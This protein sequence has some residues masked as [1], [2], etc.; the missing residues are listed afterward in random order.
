MNDGD[1]RRGGY[2]GAVFSVIVISLMAYLTFAAVQG[3]YGLFRLLQVEAKEAQLR[4]E[5]ERL[6]AR[7]AEIANR[8]LRLSVEHLDLDLLDERARSVLGLGRADEIMIR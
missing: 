1:Q 6:E 2:G 7:R 8:T 4:E 3:D 5:L